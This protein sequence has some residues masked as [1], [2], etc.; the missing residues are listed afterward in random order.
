MKNKKIFEI[1]MWLP[2]VFFIFLAS[3]LVT[4]FIFIFF[5]NAAFTPLFIFEL[6]PLFLLPGMNNLQLLFISLPVALIDAYFHTTDRSKHIRYSFIPTWIMISGIGIAIVKQPGSLDYGIRYILFAFLLIATLIDHRILLVMPEKMLE[7]KPILASSMISH[8]KI[9]PSLRMP[10]F[11]SEPALQKKPIQTIGIQPERGV[12]FVGNIFRNITKNIHLPKKIFKSKL[13]YDTRTLKKHDIGG[14][15]G[16]SV[17]DNLTPIKETKLSQSVE[18]KVSKE[19]DTS[20][21]IRN[22]LV[23]GISKDGEIIQF[24]K[25][26]QIITGYTR[27]EV[28]R[29]KIFDL[30]IPKHSQK[31]WEKMFDLAITKGVD[32]IKLPWK[33][34]EGNEILIS[35]SSFPLETKEGLI[36]S[37]C[38][39]GKSIEMKAYDKFSY[40]SQR[41]KLV[42]ESEEEKEAIFTEVDKPII[43]EPSEPYE[44]GEKLNDLRIK[45]DII[46]RKIKA[47]ENETG[48]PLSDLRDTFKGIDREDEYT[49]KLNEDRKNFDKRIAEFSNYK[50]KLIELETEIE[51]RRNYVMEQEKSL[52]ENILTKRSS[53]IKDENINLKEYSPN[54]D[55]ILESAAVVRRGILKQINSSFADLIGFETDEI[56]SRDFIDFVAHE[57]LANIEQ[58]YLNRLKGIGDSTYDTI[59]TTKNKG[60]ISVKIKIKPT[61]YKGEKAE[62]TIVNQIE[63]Q[64]K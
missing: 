22:N 45:Y 57:G 31:Q 26:C 50:E 32:N 5:L 14:K 38:F 47:I 30:L 51:K 44:I 46:N 7:R 6:T 35:W 28:L 55:E 8:E 36:K 48:K 15:M 24:N 16:E 29:R 39:I 25:E 63:N 56:L 9:S 40:D 19:I 12:F 33:T 3:F 34:R 52:R 27:G 2:F 37:I 59:F 62:I 11:E 61:I 13:Y 49:L 18:G 4:K 10:Y 42:T 54:L 58:Y 1:L 23:I 17:K 20:T 21:K 60:N 64:Q 43:S 41:D 53:L